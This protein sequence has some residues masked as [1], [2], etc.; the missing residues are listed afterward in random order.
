MYIVCEV[1]VIHTI[2]LN[3][4]LKPKTFDDMKDGFEHAIFVIPAH[5]PDGSI[6]IYI[7]IYIHRCWSYN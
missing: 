5:T 4:P 7:Y 3:D 2:I 1:N 6:F